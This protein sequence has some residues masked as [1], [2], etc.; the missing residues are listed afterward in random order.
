MRP[1]F[2]YDEA[3]FLLALRDLR[4]AAETR[5]L[6]LLEARVDD[7]GSPIERGQPMFLD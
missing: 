7:N 6:P 1:L 2:T 5:D 4:D 3:Q